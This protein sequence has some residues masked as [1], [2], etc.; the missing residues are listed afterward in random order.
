MPV[1]IIIFVLLERYP[2]TFES[3]AGIFG[4]IMFDGKSRSWIKTNLRQLVALNSV[5]SVQNRIP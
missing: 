1:A 2:F 3:A 4:D 5:D